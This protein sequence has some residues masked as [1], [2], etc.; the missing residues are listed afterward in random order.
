MFFLSVGEWNCSVVTVDVIKRDGNK[1][2][3]SLPL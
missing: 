2:R 1:G 3:F